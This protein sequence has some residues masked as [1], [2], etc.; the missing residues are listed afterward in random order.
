MQKTVE[1]SQDDSSFDDFSD[2]FDSEFKQENKQ[3][4]FD[5]LSGYNRVMTTFNDY[6]FIYVLNPVAKGYAYILPQDVRV[7]V[8]NFFDNLLFPIRFT[9]NILQLKFENAGVELGRFVVNTIWG[10]GGVMDPATKELGWKQYDEDFGQTLGHYGVGSGF[11]IV[12]PLIGPSNLR[13][14]FSMVPDGYVSPISVTGSSDIG[15]KIPDTALEA[16]AITGVKTINSVSLKL[17]QYENIKK[18]ALDLYPFLR[19]IYEQRRNQ[20]IKE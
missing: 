4:V 19:D 9:N 20:Q 11:H 7:G 15:Y 18:D 8:S 1:T 2:E 12:L 3:T 5:P 10:L 16:L 17:G 14:M 6:A 13:D